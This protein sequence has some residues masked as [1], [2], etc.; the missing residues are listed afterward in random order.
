[1]KKSTMLFIMF[2][3]VALLFFACG[4]GKS[5][6]APA[7]AADQPAAS[8]SATLSAATAI[9]TITDMANAWGALYSLNEKAINDFQ[10]MPIMGLVTPPL[11]FVAA[12]Q[13]DMMNPNNQNGRFEGKLMLAGY[14]GFVE[15][16]GAKLTFG[17]NETLAKDGF[18]PM[19]KAG[20]RMTA[21]GSLA[22]D[23]EHFIWETANERAGRKLER[24]YYEFKRLGDGSMICLA[25]SGRT[26]NFRGEEDL[27]DDV[28]YLHNGAGRYD[29][30]I[31]KGKTGPGFAAISF[32]DKGDLGKEQALELFKAM[33]YAIETSGGIQGGKLVVEK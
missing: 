18:G 26:F 6:Q 13:F 12:V 28:I 15:K 22:L 8:S 27:S 25:L 32:A 29:F 7:A 1:M 23:K 33:G 31:A 17:Y 5:P 3:G 14:Q 9:G 24:G 30:V 20:D 16:A 10:G 11:A 4:K 2:L 21:S 19:A